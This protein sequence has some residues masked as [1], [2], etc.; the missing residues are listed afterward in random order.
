MK[1][2]ATITSERA[3][4]GQGGNQF[5]DIKLTVKNGEQTSEIGIVRLQ[6]TEAGYLLAID[7]SS[8][9]RERGERVYEELIQLKVN[10]E[11]CEIGIVQEMK[12][13]CNVCGESR[14]IVNDECIRCQSTDIGYID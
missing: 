8:Y 6:P 4:K 11:K 7:R 12:P 14:H 10:K 13:I 2:C 9:G 5:L 1:L 3:S